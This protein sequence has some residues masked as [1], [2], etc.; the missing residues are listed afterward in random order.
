MSTEIDVSVVICGYSMDRLEMLTEAIDSVLAQTHG[1]VELVIIIDGNHTLHNSIVSMYGDEPSVRIELNEQN[2]GISFSRTRGAKVASGEIV[3]FIDDDAVAEPMWIAEHLRVYQT[4]NVIGVAGV[5]KP[6]WLN[7]QPAFFPPEFFWLVG[8]TEP[9]FASDGAEI[10][11]GYGS[12][13]SYRRE[14]FLR[15][16]GYD[17][18]TGRKGD[19]HI[20][21][22]EAP[23]GIKLSEKYDRPIVYTSG[24]GVWHTL[25]SYRGSFRWLL[26]RSFWQGYSKRVLQLLYPDSQVEE[27]TFV[28]GVLTR[29]V[30]KYIVKAIRKRK[31]APMLQ[32]ICCVSF[33]AAAGIGYLY[34]LFRRPGTVTN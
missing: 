4:Q 32:G 33:I 21:A 1:A 25:S 14:A 28:W 23:A 2:R 34:A 5:V 24:P 30:P 18:A 12:N 6:R 20:Q 16:G 29:A 19:R 3:A 9:D 17:S 7:S 22:H 10:R 11:N 31:M 27:R 8:C 26:F 15:V 13:V